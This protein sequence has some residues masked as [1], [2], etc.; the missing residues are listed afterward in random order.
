MYWPR[1]KALE[2]AASKGSLAPPSIPV[3]STLHAYTTNPSHTQS[4]LVP[5]SGSA[6]SLLSGKTK[7]L[8]PSDQLA[9]FREAVEGSDLTKTGLVEVLKKRYVGICPSKTSFMLT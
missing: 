6:E 1:P 3:K 2:Q 5:P 4:P 9:E 7:K 8:F